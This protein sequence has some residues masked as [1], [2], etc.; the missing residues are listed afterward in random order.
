MNSHSDPERLLNRLRLP[1]GEGWGEGR[2]ATPRAAQPLSCSARPGLHARAVPGARRMRLESPPSPPALCPK[3]RGAQCGFTLVELV[4]VISLFGILAAVGAAIMA[5]P[6]VAFANAASSAQLSDAGSR[7]LQRMADELRQALPNSV[8][9]TS[10]GN[11]FYIE[12]MPLTGVG[13]Y[14]AQVAATGTAGDPLDFADAADAAFDVLGP[15][16]TLGASSQMVIHNLGTAEGDAYSGNNRRAGL[17]YNAGSG[18]L[19]FTANGAFPSE[20]PSSRFGLVDPPVSFVCI[21]GASGAGSL[22]RLSGYGIQASQPVSLAAAPLAGATSAVLSSGITS[23]AAQYD[24]ALQNL[25]LVTLRL[26]MARG[27]GVATLVQQIAV[28]TTP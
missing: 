12:F 4:V 26:V 24:A 15:M 25:G 27:D 13:R 23:C 19:Q 6:I 10:S 14:R 9:V 3:G 21:G 22:R 11:T 20:S 28:E 8:R 5:R 1:L 18:V 2:E 16:P 7:A 17:V